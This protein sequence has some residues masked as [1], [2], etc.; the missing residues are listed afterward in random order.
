MT[1]EQYFGDNQ[2]KSFLQILN[3]KGQ[4]ADQS[5]R[6]KKE[7]CRIF[8][9]IFLTGKHFLNDF[10]FKLQVPNIF[11]KFEPETVFQ[12]DAFNEN[13]FNYKFDSA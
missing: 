5:I 10:F 8:L 6:V 11:R 2:K 4:P 9:K 7:N 1:K 12:N 13:N 3:I